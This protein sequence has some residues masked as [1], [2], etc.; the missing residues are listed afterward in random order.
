MDLQTFKRVLTAFADRPADIDLS[1]GTLLAQIRDEMIEAKLSHSEGSVWIEEEATTQPVSAFHWIVNRVA[2]LPLLADRVLSYVEDEE[3]FVHPSG[4]FVDLVEESPGDSEEPVEDAVTAIESVLS[5]QPAGISSVL[6]ITSDAGEG[7]TTLINHIARK[8]AEAFKRKKAGWLLVPV[9]LGG[10]PF[11]RLDDVIVAEL[12]NR[13]RFMLFYDAFME[14]VRLNVVVPAL[15]GFEEVFVESATGEAASALGNLINTMDGKGRV[16]VAARKAYF[17]IRSFSAQSR[18]FD[19]LN[20]QSAADFARVAISRWSVEE[21]CEY[22]KKRGLKNPE[23]V[24]RSLAQRLDADHP[25]LTRA[26]LVERLVDVAMEGN[27]A[28]LLERLGTD[29]EDYFFQFVDTIVER[30][31]TTKWIDRSGSET[32]QPLLTVDQ[33]HDLLALVAREMWVNATDVL[34]QDYL[35]LIADLFIGDHQLTPAIG[36]QVKNRLHQHSLLVTVGET[37]NQIGFDHEDFRA[38]YLGQALAEELAGASDQSLVSFLRVST[39]PPRTAEAAVNALM[40]TGTSLAATL[41]RVQAVGAAA[42]ETSYT[43]ENAGLL[44]SRLLET[45]PDRLVEVRHIN[46]PPDAARGRRWRDVEFSSCHFQASSLAESVFTN[47]R[48]SNCRFE[49]LETQR[50]PEMENVSFRDCDI[51]SLQI[52]DS[53]E[54]VFDPSSIFRKLETLGFIVEGAEQEQLPLED[55]GP[56]EETL[57]AEAGLRGFLRSTHVNENVLRQ[58]LGSRANSFFEDVLPQLL[59]KGILEPVEYKGAGQ[60]SRFKLGVPMRN[61]EPAIREARNFGEFCRLLRG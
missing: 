9:R 10:R 60:Q 16:L 38:F 29:P 7:K 55:E 44:I 35:D 53:D 24:F 40:R 57:L 23:D 1:R 42:S 13:L 22:A 33:H 50:G 19:A 32:S 18:F 37:G 25:L 46:F 21:F 4:N 49:R 31:A 27:V 36:R 52:L 43:R 58:R 47:V 41:E 3:F 12:A 14:L 26:V 2:R 6:Y 8:Q 48:F 17:E 20:H 61:I 45:K 59:E 30:E 28:T 39:L 54:R 51:G 56:D 15:D 34:R 5:R 11:M